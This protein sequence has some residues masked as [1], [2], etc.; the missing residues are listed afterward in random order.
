MNLGF[1]ATHL[2]QSLDP[3][4]RKRL[5][6]APKVSRKEAARRVDAMWATFRATLA[7]RKIDEIEARGGPAY[8]SAQ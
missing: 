4:S 5:G 1:T 8:F 3:Q 7:Q 6:Y 2:A